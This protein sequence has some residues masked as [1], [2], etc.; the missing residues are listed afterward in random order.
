[1]K[2]IRVL[3][4]LLCLAAGPAWVVNITLQRQANGSIQ[5]RVYGV[6]EAGSAL[7]IRSCRRWAV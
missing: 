4:F 6:Q 7:E 3:L 2:T 1:M 5:G